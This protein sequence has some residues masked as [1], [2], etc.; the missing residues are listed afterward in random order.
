MM[1]MRCARNMRA[2]FM[3]HHRIERVARSVNRKIA[4][5]A[6]RTTAEVGPGSGG[7]RVPQSRRVCRVLED[8]PL[9]GDGANGWGRVQTDG[10]MRL[11]SLLYSRQGKNPESEKIAAS[12]RNLQNKGSEALNTYT[13]TRAFR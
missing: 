2:G 12:Q 9:G 4:K 10:A 3:R 13:R 1:L 7:V 5:S 8:A 11:I 6:T